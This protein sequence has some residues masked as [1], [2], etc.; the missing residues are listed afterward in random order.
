MNGAGQLQQAQFGGNGGGSMGQPQ[1]AAQYPAAATNSA[2]NFTQSSPT[3]GSTNQQD[4]GVSDTDLQALLSQT[5]TTSIA[6]NLLKQFGGGGAGGSGIAGGGD[7]VAGAAMDIKEE[8][9]D[10][11]AA[12]N[13]NNK[14]SCADVPKITNRIKLENGQLRSTTTVVTANTKKDVKQEPSLKIENLF[15]QDQVP[16]FNIDMDSKRLIEICK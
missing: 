15:D 3:P 6:E 4:M 16:E 14:S 12:A 7:D 10:E 8:V 2:T 11:A 13:S 9:L 5:D 1:T